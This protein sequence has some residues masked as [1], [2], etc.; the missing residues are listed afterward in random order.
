MYIFSFFFGE[1]LVFIQDHLLFAFV[2][3]LT[4]AKFGILWQ[5]VVRIVTTAKFGIIWQIVSSGQRGL[6]MPLLDER[7]R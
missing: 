4:T 6:A 7:E 3:I 2:R 1:V 5:I